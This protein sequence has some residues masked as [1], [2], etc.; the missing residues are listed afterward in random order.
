[1][2]DLDKI[3]AAYRESLPDPEPGADFM[4][5]LWR[6]I[7]AKRSPVLVF[8]R[9][10]QALVT[11]AVCVLLAGAVMITR[12]QKAP[13]Y[14]ATYVDVLENEHASTELAYADASRTQPASTDAGA[15]APPIQ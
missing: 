9:L 2:D 14:T 8:R 13:V 11:A 5:G 10:V 1:M 3:F 6:R 15:E 7:E 12:L 4:P